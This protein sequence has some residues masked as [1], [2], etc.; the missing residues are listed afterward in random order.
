MRTQDFKGP[1]TTAEGDYVLLSLQTARYLMKNLTAARS[2]GS[3]SGPLAET[4]APLAD[5]SFNPHT[6]GRA[7]LGL[8]LEG[9]QTVDELAD[10][11][12]LD[13]L[14]QWRALCAIASSGDAL[15]ARRAGE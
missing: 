6:D 14:F 4:L 3:L 7:A 5:R 2:G 11:G 12:Y 13:K 1:N 10:L 9:A 15:E 8:P